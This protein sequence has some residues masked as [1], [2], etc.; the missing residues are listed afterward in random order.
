MSPLTEECSDCLQRS[1]DAGTG[2]GATYE[3]CNEL[4]ACED[5]MICALR[6]RCYEEPPNGDCKSSHGCELSGTD[7]GAE[8]LATIRVVEF[9]TCARTACADVCGFAAP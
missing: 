8:A 7:R 9:E 2:C 6:M 5:S 4:D 3:S 1:P